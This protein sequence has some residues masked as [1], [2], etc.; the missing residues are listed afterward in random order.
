GHPGPRRRG[1]GDQHGGPG[2]APRPRAGVG[3]PEPHGGGPGGRDADA[4]AACGPPARRRPDRP[5]D[6][7]RAQRVTPLELYQA[8]IAEPREAGTPGAERA[9]TLLT[10]HLS[11]RGYDVLEQRF[12][13]QP[14][15]LNAFPLLG[16]GLGWLMLLE[17]PLL[18]LGGLPGGLAP[19]IWFTGALAL[20]LL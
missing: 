16:A 4:G 1:A 11:S 9:R 5:G 19:L 14:A 20:G 2:P 6:F 12:L 10:E 13:F 15:A 7:R 3:P 8:L 17:I 18:L